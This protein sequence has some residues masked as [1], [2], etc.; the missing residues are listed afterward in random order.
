MSA[1]NPL[2]IDIPSMSEK[3]LYEYRLGKCFKLLSNFN[4]E[5]DITVHVSMKYYEGFKKV[6][7]DISHE[8]LPLSP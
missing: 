6:L 3:E 5:K 7:E 4:L 8:G 1:L 2:H